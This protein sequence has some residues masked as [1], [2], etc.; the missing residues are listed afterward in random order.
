MPMKKW[1]TQWYKVVLGL[2]RIGQI[3]PVPHVH[4]AG[5]YVLIIVWKMSILG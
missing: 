4:L 3:G 1:F 5:V 2:F